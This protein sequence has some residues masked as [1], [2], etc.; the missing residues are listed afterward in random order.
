MKI[1]LVCSKHFYDKVPLIKEQ[2]EQFG[3]TISLPMSF[4]NPNSESEMKSV[5]EREHREF[6][7]KMMRAQ[8]EEVAA[9]DAV[10]VLNFEKN[11]QTNYIG[12]ATFLEIYKAFEL[13]K[14]IFLYNP[15][16]EN[17]L[18][19]ELKGMAPQVIFG[20]LSKIR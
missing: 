11:G 9:N 1:F 6:K 8:A 10:L 20:K 18:T 15:I 5:G 2:L 16:P 17:I 7:Q 12:G 3:H 19:D 4:D 13:R 14:K